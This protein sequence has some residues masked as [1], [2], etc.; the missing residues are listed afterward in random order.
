MVGAAFWNGY[1]ASL[2]GKPMSTC[3]FP[4]GSEK[5]TEWLE[6]WKGDALQEMLKHISSP[7]LGRR[8][9]SAQDDV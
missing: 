9:D 1:E 2:S 8:D 4:A 7:R 3:P 5:A 6:G